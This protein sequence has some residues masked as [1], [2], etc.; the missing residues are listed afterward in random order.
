MLFSSVNSFMNIIF[1]K[2]QG[3]GN[4]FIMIDNR[5]KSIFINQA[6]IAKLCHRNYGVGADGLIMIEK[7]ESVDFSMRYYNADGKLGSMCG[8]GA[9]CAVAYSRALGFLPSQGLF[10]AYDG[11]HSF[12]IYSHDQISISMMNVNNVFQTKS[13]LEINTGSPHLILFKPKVLSMNVKVEGAKIR[14]NAK[15]REDGINVNFVEHTSNYLLI[16]TFERGVENET[17]ACGSGATAAAIAAFESGIIDSNKIEVK[18]LGGLL[19]VS[20]DKKGQVYK[21]IFLTGPA[22]FS[23]KGEIDV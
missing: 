14:N 8:N 13:G 11:I 7:D 5:D 16:R 3:A 6:K 9:R 12:R 1:Q 18:A 17:H 19:K 2:Y 20:F 10:K 23:F 4:D 15:Y 22:M 21:N